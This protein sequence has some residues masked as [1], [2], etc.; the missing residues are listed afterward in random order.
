MLR[1]VPP[2]AGAAGEAR[3][4]NDKIVPHGDVLY[5]TIRSVRKRKERSHESVQVWVRSQLAGVDM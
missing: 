5:G 4:G 2:D 3:G 1:V